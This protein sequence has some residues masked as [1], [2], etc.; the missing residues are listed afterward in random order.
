MKTVRPKKR[1][2]QHFLNTPEIARKIADTFDGQS[3][4]N[5]LE[6]GPG[7]GVLTQYL[8][9]KKRAL[10]LIELDEESVAYLRVHFPNLAPNTFHADFLKFDLRTY[11]KGAPFAVMGNFPY[12]ISTQIVFK[13]LDNRDQIPFFSGMF[14]KEVAQR[15]CEGPGNKSY[16][17]LSVLTQIFYEV[18]YCFSVPP[19][20]FVPPPKVESGVLTM[21][22]K[23]NYE[24]DCDVPLLFKLVKTSF[25]QRRKTL[26]NSLKSLG[27]PKN[28]TEDSIFELRPE[29]LSGTQFVE[30]AQKIAHGHLSD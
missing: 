27:L 11:F 20:V 6:I 4:P 25:Q 26:R 9:T 19:Q 16:G 13:V 17:I 14:Q 5:I 15:I 8:L 1:L 3:V 21:K 22:R 30:L 28:L 2:G 18:S 10:H 12:N 23:K 7:T 29:K 24:P